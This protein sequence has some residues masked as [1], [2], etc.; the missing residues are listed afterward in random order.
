MSLLEQDIM[1]KRQVDENAMELNT[2]NDENKKYK[3]RAVYDTMV[4]ARK[5]QGYLSGL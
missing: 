1:R 3:V 4:Y 5:S 2:G